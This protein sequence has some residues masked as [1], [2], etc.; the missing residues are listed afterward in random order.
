[1]NR[2]HGSN[3]PTRTRRT[4][5]FAL[6]LLPA[7]N[8][9]MQGDVRGCQGM[10]DDLLAGQLPYRDRVFEYPPYVIPIFLLPRL[11]GGGEDNYLE[12]FK[13][14]AEGQEVEFE[15]EAG[16]KGLHAANVQ[17]VS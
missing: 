4:A 7:F 3:T 9:E 8:A 11:F 12:G 15:I 14:L 1:M 17:R 16:A 10:A 5:L 13:T 6:C 2:M